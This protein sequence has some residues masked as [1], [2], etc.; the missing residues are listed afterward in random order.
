[1]P[2]SLGPAE[3]LVIL[4]DEREEALLLRDV[5]QSVAREQADDGG[6]AGDVLR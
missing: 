6:Q 5:A 1:M 2:T 3:I 4:V